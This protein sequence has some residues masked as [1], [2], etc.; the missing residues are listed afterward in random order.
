MR[1]VQFTRLVHEFYANME[2]I[3]IPHIPLRLKTIV[4]KKTID[5]ESS[6]LSAACGIVNIGFVQYQTHG[7]IDLD[8]FRSREAMKLLTGRHYV[9]KLLKYL[10]L[11]FSI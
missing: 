4:K 1:E 8:V 5:I 2:V 9:F 6:I 7:W 10:V 11:Y 3:D